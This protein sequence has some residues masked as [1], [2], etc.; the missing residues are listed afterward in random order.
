MQSSTKGIEA[1]YVGE[2]SR[3]A[4]ERANDHVR[5]YRDMTE[6]SHMFKHAKDKHDGKMD[7]AW[8]FV[9]I[10]TFQKSLTR[11]LSEA[12]RIK[13]RGEDNVL[14]DKG[15]FNRCA[16]PEI[17][18][19]HNDKIWKEE[20]SKFCNN[21]NNNM[22]DD[23][24]EDMVAVANAVERVRKRKGDTDEGERWGEVGETIHEHQAK[25]RFLEGDHHEFKSNIIATSL[26]IALY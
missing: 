5:D 10:K 13:L 8:K 22:K 3:S 26:P 21:N 19:T 4:H 14:N 9:V 6:D 17:A 20:K 7:L 23:P 15:V 2:S 12:V 16:I 1:V 11:Q 25:R 18:V 24:E